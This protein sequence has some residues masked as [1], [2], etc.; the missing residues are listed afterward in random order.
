[1][2]DVPS[3][4]MK[5]QYISVVREISMQV[6]MLVEGWEGSESRRGVFEVKSG[7]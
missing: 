1:M 5:M 2:V 6:S 7:G 3:V 4:K